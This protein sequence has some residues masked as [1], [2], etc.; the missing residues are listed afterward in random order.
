MWTQGTVNGYAFW[1][2]H[3]EEG[4]EEYGIGGGRISKLTIR[5][6]GR[7]MYNYDRGLDFDGLDADGKATYDEIIRRYN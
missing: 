3:Y 5:K 4:S 1:V 2:K 7:E 6:G